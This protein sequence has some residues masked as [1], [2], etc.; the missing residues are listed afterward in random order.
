M[1]QR[2]R[3]AGAGH[4]QLAKFRWVF[5][6][7][8]WAGCCLPDG[9]VAGAIGGDAHILTKKLKKKNYKNSTILRPRRPHLQKALRHRRY[10]NA[11][12]LGNN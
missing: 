2:V 5:A 7:S 3:A 12:G 11:H 9:L 8:L 1:D 4:D 10:R 6:D